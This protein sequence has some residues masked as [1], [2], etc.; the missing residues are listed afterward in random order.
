[1]SLARA[2]GI[3]AYAMSVVN[4]DRGVFDQNYLTGD[5]LDDTIVVAMVDGKERMFD[6][7]QRYATYGQLAWIHTLVTGVRQ[8]DGGHTAI[9]STPD[10]TYKQNLVIRTADLHLAPDG[11]LSG[12]AN[13]NYTG[14]AALRWRQKALEGDQ[15]ELKREFED[16][17]K[18]QLAPGAI[19]TLDHF[20]GLDDPASNLMARMNVS[21][22]LGTSTGK[23]AF[24]PLAFFSGETYPFSTSHRD[25]PVDL[26]YPFL[27]QDVIVLHLP[28]TMHLES[29][30][31]AAK[32]TLP[33]M[34]VYTSTAKADATSIT[35][36]RT[37]AMANTLYTAAEY[38]KLK[39]FLDDV[40]THDREQAVLTLPAP[41][42]GQ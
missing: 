7:G 15:Q 8:I 25:S 32:A 24:F 6:P 40:S 28:P 23:R 37:L 41:G 10:S 38:P 4:R 42:S 34:A 30:P 35:Y 21:G 36:N 17:L 26:R 39:G 2:A 14:A 29:T 11:T 18:P 27:A 33:Q 9:A 3:H 20:L 12:T 31:A 19:V 1:M 16:E 22:N 13:I 5:Q